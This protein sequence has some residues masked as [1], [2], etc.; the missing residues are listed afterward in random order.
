MTIVGAGP[1]YSV[2]RG[3]GVGLYGKRPPAGST[4]VTLK[5]FAIIGNVT[6]RND[7][8][9]LA[10]VGG[11]LGGGSLISNLWIQHHN[12]GV[13]LDGPLNGIIVRGLR[14]IDNSA[15]GVNF[16]RGIENGLVE[17]NFIRNSGDDGLALWSHHLPDQRILLRHNTVIAPILANGIAIYGGRDIKIVGNLVADTLTE[18]GGIHLGNRFAASPLTGRITIDNNLVVRGGSFDP[19][20]RVGIGALWLYALDRPIDADIRVVNL[21]LVDSTLPAIQFIGKPIRSVRFRKLRIDGA[22]H[23]L[24][25]QSAGEASFSGVSADRLVAGGVARCHAGFILSLLDDAQ[26][27]SEP[28]SVSCTAVTGQRALQAVR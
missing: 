18:G 20:W 6:R 14:I 28:P 22:Y 13:W 4:G 3:N 24:Q 9:P 1:W 17:Q 25:I 26:A 27:L 21:D 15:D 19:H 11:A 12:A 23:A 10:G 8:V 2:L 7:R 16:H 5:D